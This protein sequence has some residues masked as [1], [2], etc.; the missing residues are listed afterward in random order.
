MRHL[1][2]FSL[3]ISLWVSGCA[4]PETLDSTPVRVLAAAP[5][6]TWVDG[7]PAQGTTTVVS[8]PLLTYRS[9]EEH[10]GYF[11]SSTW[12]LPCFGRFAQ[13]DRF[14][15]VEWEGAPQ[16]PPEEVDPMASPRSGKKRRKG[17]KRKR[18]GRKGDWRSKLRH[19]SPGVTVA[20]PAPS[21]AP[22]KRSGVTSAG[23]RMDSDT[24]RVRERERRGERRGKRETK[25]D[26][27]RPEGAASSEDPKGHLLL[28]LPRQGKVVRQRP[29]QRTEWDVLG[30]LIRHHSS[31]PAQVIVKTRGKKRGKKRSRTAVYE[32]GET[33]DE[34]RFLP[35]FSYHKGKKSAGWVAWPLLGFGYHRQGKKRAL[36]LFYFLKIPLN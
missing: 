28:K 16:G 30:S 11:E 9:S 14:V 23:P 25:R 24:Q 18:K 13:T 33:K 2:F 26:R 15:K 17:K 8:L 19:R 27:E 20:A 32:V 29:M 34:F 5:G 7:D 35:L 3:L 21:P 6:L 36:R 22:R 12:V 31:R 1:Q 4:S 10:P